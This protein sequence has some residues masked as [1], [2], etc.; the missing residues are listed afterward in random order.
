MQDS[1]DKVGARIRAARAYADIT[2]QKKLAD[3]IGVGR[4]VVIALEADQREPTVP[5]VRRIATATG[6]PMGFLL[7]GWTAPP[8]FAER[9]EALEDELRQ[10]RSERDALRQTM[11]A[12]GMLLRDRLAL[13]ATEALELGLAPADEAD[14]PAAGGPPAP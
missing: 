9:L 5:E 3:L 2:S 13:S 7:D 6:V 1:D 4:E 14:R 10:G 12:I 8:G 11:L